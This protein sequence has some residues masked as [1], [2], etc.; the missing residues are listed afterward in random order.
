MKNRKVLLVLITAILTILPLLAACK[1]G[2]GEK[3][4]VFKCDN[5]QTV[6]LHETFMAGNVVGEVK[7]GDEGVVM[8]SRWGKLYG[9]MMYDVVVGDQ[10]GW[11]CEEYLTFK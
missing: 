8:D 10:R 11:V 1:S 3:R 6:E 4:V 9:C 7:V 5:C 2:S